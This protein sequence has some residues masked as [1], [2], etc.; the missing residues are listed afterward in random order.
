[1]INTLKLC[2]VFLCMYV[3]LFSHFQNVN[4]KICG[5]RSVNF[6]VWSKSFKTKLILK[7]LFTNFFYRSNLIF[8]IVMGCGIARFG[9]G[10]D[11]RLTQVCLYL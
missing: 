4:M 2:D 11:I 9:D 3:F 5:D 1:M 6:I 10:Y 8:W 7:G